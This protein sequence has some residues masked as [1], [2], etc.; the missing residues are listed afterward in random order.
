[1]AGQCTLRAALQEANRA[2]GP[3]DDRVQHP[4]CGDAHDRA[5]DDVAAAQ[6]REGGITIDGFT[7]PGSVAQHRPARR[8][9]QSTASSSSARAK[10]PSTVCSWRPPRTTCSAASRC[11]ASGARSGSTAG[12]TNTR[13][14]GNMIGLTPTGAFDPGFSVRAA[15][16]VRR[17]PGWC[18]DTT[19]SARRVP[20]I[21]TSCRAAGTSGSP[22]TTGRRSST[23]SRT[24][25]S[26]ST[27]PA[28]RPAAT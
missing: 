16:V 12:T 28:R 4:G 5:G 7:Q 19:R 13:G 10:P 20:R 22:P 21:A 2:G 8:Q 6:Q 1:M 25:S 14:R 23:T 26:V 27:R 24:T 3:V 18:A 15:V 11:T 9:R 17:D